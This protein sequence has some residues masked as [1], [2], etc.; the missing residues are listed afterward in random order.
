MAEIKFNK[1]SLTEI[2]QGSQR[3]SESGRGDYSLLP[4]VVIAAYAKHLQEGVEKGYPRNNWQKGQPLSRLHSS[5]LRHSFQ[6]LDG[7]LDEPHDRAVLFN[8]GAIIYTR[9]AIKEGTLP[10]SLEDVFTDEQ[11]KEYYGRERGQN[12]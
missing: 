11:F 8:I 6:L 5:L 4:S 1:D 9:N 2:G 12:A 3:S 7:Q 10:E